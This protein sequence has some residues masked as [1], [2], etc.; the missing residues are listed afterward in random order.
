MAIGQELLD[1][2]F[3]DLVR[4]L[5]AA[6]AEGQME[7]DRAAIE[8]V[9][10]LT[11]TKV[12]VI[13]EVTEVIE[14]A[15]KEVEVG[16]SKQKVAYTGASITASSAAPISLNLLQAG[17]MPTFYQF[18]EATIEV[19]LSISMKR[20]QET[21][22]NPTK[23][24]AVAAARM[25]LFNTKAFASAVNYRSASTYSYT[26]EGSSVLRATMK[27]VPPPPR[28]TPRTVTVNAFTTPPTVTITD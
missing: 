18:T 27:P 28:L 16:P 4:N 23:G 11:A 19:K 14:P 7:L 3:A 17:L 21:S 12:D 6:I 5:A 24:P 9:K 25:K 26:A 8:T 10:F 22:S 1:I 13:P 2:P 20:E 15:P